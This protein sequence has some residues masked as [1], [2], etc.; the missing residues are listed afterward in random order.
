M[1]E[2]ETSKSHVFWCWK[3]KRGIK[4]EQ[5]N[6]TLC[7]VYT[8]KAKSSL[9]ML[10]SATEKDEIDAKYKE[11]DLTKGFDYMADEKL[12]SI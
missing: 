5:P 11:I 4:L 12:K 3:Q 1:K 8:N 2:D 6:T 10:E 9:N 7:N